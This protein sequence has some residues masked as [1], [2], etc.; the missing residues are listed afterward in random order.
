MKKIILS[1]ALFFCGI[2]TISA[3]DNY[4]AS[5]EEDFI[6]VSTIN[7]EMGDP[8]KKKMKNWQKIEK[9][10]MFALS[11]EQALQL[12]NYLNTK[13]KKQMKR[14][15]ILFWTGLAWPIVGGLVSGLTG[16]AI[17]AGISA[18]LGIGQM[19]WGY[20]DMYGARQ[21]LDN[22]RL[23]IVNVPLLQ[24]DHDNGVSTKLGLGITEDQWRKD[25]AIGPKISFVF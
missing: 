19:T 18:G 12:K 23:I 8:L 22:S 20:M 13:G 7:T 6:V 3:E 15:Q 11:T 24:F 2:T 4:T 10:D 9:N 21:K 1:L 25:M 16:S 17:P 14:G 5:P